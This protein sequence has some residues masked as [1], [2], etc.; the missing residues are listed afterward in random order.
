MEGS[1]RRGG[2]QPAGPRLR[3]A[4][5]LWVCTVFSGAGVSC[6]RTVPYSGRGAWGARRALGQVAC[7]LPDLPKK[8]YPFLEISFRQN[9]EGDSCI[10]CTLTM[11]AAVRGG[12]TIFHENVPRRGHLRQKGGAH[13][14]FFVVGLFKTPRLVYNKGNGSNLQKLRPRCALSWLP[15]LGELSAVG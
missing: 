11:S 15:P 7:I 6:R 4:G 12:R 2:E 13:G 9:A 1:P 10:L 14:N 5:W 3:W 8:R